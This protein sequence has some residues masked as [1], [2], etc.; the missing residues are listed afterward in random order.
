MTW[1]QSF[2]IGVASFSAADS[3]AAALRYSGSSWWFISIG[4]ADSL[5]PRV[6]AA[7]FPA[8]SFIARKVSS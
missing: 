7:I 4:C 1:V 5:N 8:S 6:I 3:S 2:G